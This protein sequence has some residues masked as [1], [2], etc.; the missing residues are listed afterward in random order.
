MECIYW[1]LHTV[2]LRAKLSGAVYCYRSCLWVCLQWAGG[3]C[4]NLTTASARA[5]LASLWVLFHIS[6][7][8]LI[9]MY[10]TLTCKCGKIFSKLC[11]RFFSHNS[12][13]VHGG[14]EKPG[15][16]QPPVK[17]QAVSGKCFSTVYSLHRLLAQSIFLIRE[18]LEEE[19]ESFWYE[20]LTRVVW[21][22]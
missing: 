6:L 17:G 15:E 5:V 16:E 13:Y 18:D 3:R 8:L 21:Y 22:W 19:T 7:S 12:S 1:H 4:P 9:N 10:G 20:S 2:T 14:V 11:C